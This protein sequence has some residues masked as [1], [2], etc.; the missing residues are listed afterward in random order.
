VPPLE[1]VGLGRGRERTDTV[2]Y[3]T[4]CRR[5]FCSTTKRSLLYTYILT[6]GRTTSPL[7][8]IGRLRRK[9]RQIW[10]AAFNAHLRRQLQRF[11]PT[12]SPIAKI[13][14][15]SPAPTSVTKVRPAF[16][17]QTFQTVGE[18]FDPIEVRPASSDCRAIFSS[19]PFS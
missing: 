14:M 19:T 15:G 7:P 3:L 10:V 4:T 9:S 1:Q 6:S 17:D 8:A 13:R 12:R 11:S 16:P 5:A 2:S 18:Y